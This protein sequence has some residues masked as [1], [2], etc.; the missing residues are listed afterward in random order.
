[1]ERRYLVGMIEPQ[2]DF[3]SD[4]KFSPE[5]LEKYQP[6]VTDFFE[7]MR[8]IDNKEELIQLQKISN[9]RFQMSVK[10]FYS[11]LLLNP[12]NFKED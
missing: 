12:I 2:K 4:F 11:N 6:I 7:A 10:Y 1:M 9:W 8:Q 5:F 3:D